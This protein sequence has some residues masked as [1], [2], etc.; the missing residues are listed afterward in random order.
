MIVRI[1]TEG[2]YRLPDSAMAQLDALDDAT[3]AAVDRDDSDGFRE[4]F[5]RLLDAA[6]SGDRLPDDELVGSDLILPPPDTTLADAARE[7]VGE[8]LIPD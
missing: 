7:F 1:A 6:R 8:G 3:V 5:E 2:Q 4:A